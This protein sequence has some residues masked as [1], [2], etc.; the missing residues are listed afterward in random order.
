[1]D[2]EVNRIN[3]AGKSTSAKVDQQFFRVEL[4]SNADTCC[5][6]EGVMIVNATDR[7]VTATPFVKSLGT[8]KKVPIV[9]AAVAYDDPRSGKVVV[10]I[11]HQALYFP[12]MQRCLMCPMQLRL[13]DVVINERPKFLTA[14]PTEKD[15][16]IVVEDLLICLSIN[17][18]ASYFDARTP[19]KK[20]YDECDRI[21]LTYPFPEWCPHD[22]KFAE[23]EANRTDDDGCV[24]SVRNS[25]NVSQVTHDEG[26]LLSGFNGWEAVGEEQI[27]IS[28]I[29]SD[30]FKL[31]SDVLCK[32]WGIG[33]AL[34]ERTIEATTQLRVRTVANPSIERR[35]PTGDRPLRYRRLDHP[36]YHDTMY[37]KVK[38][39]R[40]NTCCEIYVTSFG[41]SRV[42]PMKTESE[43][44]ETLDLFLGRYGVPEALISDGAKAYT[45]GEFK[46]K[47]KQAGIFCKLTDPYSP[48]Q[49][50]AESEIREVKR[51][52]TRWQ[53]R[54]KSPRRLWD[55]AVELASVVR[56]H[57]ALD[58][59]KLDGQVP[60]TKMLGQT[61]DI[62][63]IYAFAWYDWIYYHDSVVS[64]PEPKM[65]L[66]RYIGPT[67][68]EAGSVLTAKV[69]T[70]SG[71]VIRRNTFRHLTQLEL[72][73]P[74]VKEEQVRF[75]VKVQKRLG[76]AFHDE[77]EFSSLL[78][79]SAVSEDYTVF[80]DDDC[81][82]TELSDDQETPYEPE[83]IDGYITAQVLLPRGDQYKL[84]TVIE[85]SVDENAV[86]KGRANNNPILDSREYRVEFDDG[87]VLEYAANIIAENLY[88][89]V[90]SEGRRYL[91]MDSIIDHKSDKN[92]VAKD[93]EFVTLNGKQHRKKTT[94]GWHFNVQWKDGTT[95]WEPLKRLKETNPV[96]VADY[97]VANKIA[98]EP[99]FAWWV[100]FTLKTRNRIIAAVNKRYMLRTHK[101][102]I[103]VPK[104]VEEALQLDKESGTTH[105]TDAI[106]L[107]AKNV[108]VAFEDLE[109]GDEVPI[110]YQFVR[111]HMI[112][113]VKAGSLNRKASYVAGGHMTEPPA[114][115]TYASVVSRESI[116]IGLLIAALNDL[117]VFAA[118]IQNAYLTSP[119]EE[120]IWTTLG[121]EF[122]PHRQGKKAIVV[123]ALYGLKSA[124]AAFRNHLASCLGHLGFT[125][126]RGDPDVW[127]RP[128][129]KPNGEEYY[130][131]MF[132]YTDDILAIGLN[133]KEILM[134][135]NKYFKLKP[136]SIHPP[137][138]YL[139]TKIK[140]TSLPNGKKAWGQSSSHYVREAVKNLEEWMSSNGYHF[141]KKAET[142]MSS[143][144]RPELDITAELDAEKANY[145]QSVIG[146]LRWIIE[147]GRLDITTEVSMLAAHMAAPREG[148]LKAA[149]QVFAYLK[150]KHNARLIYDPTYPK[151]DVNEFKD[152]ENWTTFYGDV[153][154][155][156]PA[157]APKPRGKSVVLRLFVDADHAANMETRRSRTGYVQMINTAVVN[158][159]SKKQGS[160]ETSTFGSEFVA[161][162]TAMEA[163][164]GLR[165]KLRMMGVPI[166]GPTYVFCDN[167]S[168]VSNTSKA[169]SVLK[170]KSNS[171]AYHAV[172]EA[173]A[174]KEILIC[175]IS[176]DKN[177]ADIMTKVLPAGQRRTDLVEM[178]LWDITL[179]NSSEDQVDG[180]QK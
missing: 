20:E 28:G 77:K 147:T 126:S 62:S 172:R 176:T 150:K 136:D 74:E 129:V 44:H 30:K 43:V 56:S 52:V 139:G 116:R 25:R 66:G 110:G 48:W 158:W 164:R 134:K 111:C 161:L 81:Q 51:L 75:D 24:R 88:S 168:V 89:Q 32:N 173:V 91:L 79:I 94:E 11:I 105:W 49:N 26:D 63:F 27:S 31:T 37:S 35:W 115:L 137:D 96:D 170:K 120:K 33:K 2:R 112:F 9:T 90:D 55:H 152:G 128:A 109:E 18:V 42:F 38:S 45:G 162:K 14:H 157:N 69:L 4:D 103:R 177:V 61:A 54:S 140:I 59:Y 144:Y 151:I 163:N 95:T 175:Y 165:Y 34:A 72:D 148:H 179:D 46:K 57:L 171:I 124:G 65:Q 118:D 22:P 174:M 141:S 113:D 12:E 86:P 133:P 53:V 117:D 64:F 80:D 71:D 29:N 85:R 68:P 98:C 41:W 106:A 101:F 60:E 7:Y 73:S 180:G 156:I 70:S 39:L 155:A 99:A 10:L 123:R 15:H 169:E 138:D 149:L 92:A 50:C 5:V 1:M 153:Q 19:T 76:E 40:G 132:V 100:P 93:D 114:A 36:V 102:G 67:E 104:T 154:E 142:P 58:L 23:E 178:L 130:E 122:G 167:Q 127:F 108:N 119:C 8:I 17:K 159:F 78:N 131:Y 143:S 135:L 146:V 6:G 13:N 166:D 160:I 47:A 121:P 145:Y 107:E 84:G 87:E 83:V 21:E 82:G 97:V 3:S 125:S 16:A